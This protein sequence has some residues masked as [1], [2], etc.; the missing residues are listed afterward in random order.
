MRNSGAKDFTSG[1]VSKQLFWFALSFMA[2]NALQVLYNTIDMM[3]VGKFVGTAGLSAVS[4]SGQIVNFFAMICLGVSNAGQILVSQAV[5][6]GKREKMTPIIGTL[7]C[8]LMILA[9]AFS[10]IIFG[11]RNEILTIM[12]IPAESY[13]MALEYLVICGA[14]MIFT[15]GYNMVSAVLRGMG[16]ARRPLL[17]IVIASVTNLVLDILFTGILGFGVA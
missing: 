8:L 12:K 3:I 10:G 6:S 16:D 7:F 2:S 13:D 17:F 5:G 4:Q 14:G 9:A 11:I 15:A 1:N